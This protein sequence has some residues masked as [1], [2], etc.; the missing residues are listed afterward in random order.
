MF[1]RFRIV[2]TNP[3]GPTIVVVGQGLVLLFGH[4]AFYLVHDIEAHGFETVG[5]LLFVVTVGI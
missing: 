4:H 2:V 5:G 1:A 3:M